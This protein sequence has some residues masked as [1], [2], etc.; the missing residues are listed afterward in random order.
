MDNLGMR[1]KPA[2]LTRN[3][4]I[5]PHADGDQ[6]VSIIQCLVSISHTVHTRHSV[7][8]NMALGKAAD[9]Q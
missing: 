8:Q 2:Y 7:A 5:K 6:Y 9:T 1:R 4:V 3:P